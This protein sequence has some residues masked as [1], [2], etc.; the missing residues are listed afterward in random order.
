[1]PS[2]ETKTNAAYA[3][4]VGAGKGLRMNNARPKQF[5]E[6]KGL[7]VIAYALKAFDA[8]RKISRI[9]LVVSPEEAA[10]CRGHILAG[11]D[12]V[13]PVKLVA[14]GQ[15]RQDSV[16]AGLLAMEG[17]QGVVAIHDGVR[18]FVAPPRI[19]ECIVKAGKSGA[20]MLGMPV[21]DTLKRV[22]PSNI[23]VETVPRDNMWQAQTPQA[24]QYPLI[25]SAHDKAVRE[26]FVGTD[27]ASLVERY[28]GEV[29]IIAGSAGNIKLTRPEDMAL[30][31]AL[32]DAL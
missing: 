8:S 2:E 3:I 18:P 17:H 4:I 21:G 9:Y 15:R 10:F 19:D 23:I 32:L 6:L 22:G 7:P 13:K 1:M 26:G 31:E 12:L 5:L 20:C 30:A 28:G 29:R 16:Y 27:D 11:L 24:F 25:R 14:G